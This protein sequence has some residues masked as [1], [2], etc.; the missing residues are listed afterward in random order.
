MP[1][2]HHSMLGWLPKERVEMVR[3]EATLKLCLTWCCHLILVHHRPDDQ[4]SWRGLQFV[5]SLELSEMISNGRSVRN[6]TAH[7]ASFQYPLHSLTKQCQQE[8]KN[9]QSRYKYTHKREA[10]QDFCLTENYNFTRKQVPWQSQIEL[11]YFIE[12]KG[13]ALQIQMIR[14]TALQKFIDV[15]FNLRLP[16]HLFS[17]EVVVLITALQKFTDA[18]REKCLP[19]WP[20]QINTDRRV[21]TISCMFLQ[22]VGNSGKASKLASS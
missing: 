21:E 13:T 18:H 4:L 10:R 6:C 20:S 12:E 3:D 19:W 8:P 2:L 1:Q 14:I 7:I 15:Q 5:N 17:S 22:T 16:G 9:Y 11:K